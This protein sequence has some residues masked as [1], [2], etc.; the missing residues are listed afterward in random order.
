ML[1]KNVLRN[2][3]SFWA[4]A[5]AALVGL[6]VLVATADLGTAAGNP[7][8]V[9][10]LALYKGA[11][12]QQILE[13]GAKKEGTLTFYTT[14]ILTQNVRPIMNAFQKKYPFIKVRIW[15][16]STNV[17]LP[18]ILQEYKAGRHSADVVEGAKSAMLVLQEQGII[19]PFYFPDLAYINEDTI[20]KAP[21]E[22]AFRVAFRESHI[23]LGYNTKLIK[24]EELPK[25]YQDFLDPK[26]KGKIPIS[27]ADAGVMWLAVML[28]AYGED[29]LTRMAEQD[30]SPQVVSS[31]GIF[32]LIIAGEYT[33]SPTMFDSHAMFSKQKGASVDWVP[34]EPVPVLV[35]EVALAKHAPHPHAALLLID[36]ELSKECA[37]ILKTKG[38]SPTRKDITG[39]KTYKKF[40]GANS[41]AEVVK[42]RK[43]YDRLFLKK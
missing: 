22:G 38:Y 16:G 8:T 1:S 36:F 34:L 18:R 37:E 40:Y 43:L 33:L 2:T 23:G 21:G 7:K 31:R 14:G 30:F 27:S 5:S 41:A 29:F 42:W 19:R 3:Y 35:G 11:D 12:R 6:A 9:A 17:L 4:V 28:T 24:R 39:L 26:W 20:T 10:E 25:T 15:R 32:D 13:D